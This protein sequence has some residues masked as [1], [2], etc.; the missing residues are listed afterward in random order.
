M[1]NSI[2]VLGWLLSFIA[3]C[4]MAVPFWIVWTQCGIGKA[5]FDF[6]PEKYLS[7]GFWDTVGIFV[8]VSIL[9]TV[10]LPRMYSSTS[11]N[12]EKKK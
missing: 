10:A 12:T 6:L 8:C 11:L 5:Y 3:N 4:S 2:P 1:V 9:K 7:V